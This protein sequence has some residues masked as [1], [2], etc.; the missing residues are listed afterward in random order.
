M[1]SPRVL[2]RVLGKYSTSKIAFPL[3]Q[4]ARTARLVGV[5]EAWRVH[6]CI[7]VRL[8]SSPRS[9]PARLGLYRSGDSDG[10]GL[11]RVFIGTCLLQLRFRLAR[12]PGRDR[13]GEVS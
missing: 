7:D 9:G 10:G 12:A 3:V 5:V 1:P 11:R 4:C 2:I 13:G 8:I 6:L